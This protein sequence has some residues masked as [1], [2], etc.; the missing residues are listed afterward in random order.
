MNL[1]RFAGT[2][3]AVALAFAATSASA[4]IV[5]LNP[6][7]PNTGAVGGTN[8]SLDPAFTTDKATTNFG[9]LLTVN[10]LAGVGVT[11]GFTETG[12][13]DFNEFSITPN[14]TS[15]LNINYN[16]YATFT[17]TGGG[18]WIGNSFIADPTTVSVTATVY[19]S[20]GSNTTS[21]LTFCT[22]TAGTPTGV[23]TMGS[24]DFVLG[25]ATLS[26]ANSAIA[27]E[28]SGGTASESFD[29][30]LTFSPAAGTS[31]PTGLWELPFPFDMQL[32]TSAVG[33]SGLD[34]VGTF[35]TT[36]GGNTLFTTTVTA[37]TRP[38]GAGSGN[39]LFA[40][41]PEPSS[42]A[43]LGLAFTLLGIRRRRTRG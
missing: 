10:S 17:I 19:G 43:L 29:A 26:Q 28:G 16:I 31:G 33:T 20:P 25:T 21:G 36:S 6:S 2:A 18:Q 38:I 37:G 7:A 12:F 34:G 9:S 23:C 41:V 4:T 30:F 27:T 24:S 11:S 22:P 15:G 14:S 3:L 35:F 8:L 42:I 13:L 32:S 40:Q 1:H 39:V 5:T